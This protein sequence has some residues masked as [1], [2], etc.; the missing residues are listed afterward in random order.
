M[1]TPRLNKINGAV[2]R[3]VISRFRAQPDGERY[4]KLVTLI[5]SDATIGPL[6]PAEVSALGMP[7]AG[8]DAEVVRL[9]EWMLQHVPRA[10]HYDEVVGDIVDHVPDEVACDVCDGWGELATDLPCDRCNGTGTGKPDLSEYTD[11]DS[12]ALYLGPEIMSHI[13]A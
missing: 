13:D 3:W 12:W 5:R 9:R 7:Y 8:L 11:V 1:T 4:L 6:N 2:L 10:V